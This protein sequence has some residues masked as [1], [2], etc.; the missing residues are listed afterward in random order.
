MPQKR[1][2]PDAAADLPEGVEPG[3]LYG[4]VVESAPGPVLVVDGD[5]TV[6]YANAAVEEV[7]GY[8]PR[9]AVNEPLSTL[10][11]TRPTDRGWATMDRYLETGEASVARD[12]IVVPGERR[13]GRRLSLSATLVEYP[14]DS[15]F[16]GMTFRDVTDMLERR[17]DLER[18]N[19]R[20]NRFASVLSHDL[21][22]PLNSARV[23][24]TLAREEEGTDHLDELESIHARMADIVDDVLALSKGVEGGETESV[25]LAAV[26]ES[27]WSARADTDAELVVETDATVEA[28]PGRV[29]TIF[30]NLLENAVRH[31]GSDVRVRLGAL[32][33]GEGFWI[34][35]DGPGIPADRRED[36]FEQGYTTHEEGTGLGLSIVR[37]LALAHGWEIAV[38]EGSDGGARFEV[39]GPDLAS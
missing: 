31:A 28:H 36:V 30:E 3:D 29:R 22:E 34:E 13:D 5:R 10:V 37:E 25:D 32:D 17:R 35:D 24:L 20:L 16:V 38:T 18:E 4:V 2:D 23:Q 39:R 15:R 14:D 9:E 33:G 27:V 8:R 7:F 1:V 11:P 12:R 19:R 6:R 26:A 21:R